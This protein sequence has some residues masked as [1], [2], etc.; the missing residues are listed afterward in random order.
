MSLR[1]FDVIVVGAGHAGIEAAGAAAR[2][3]CKTLLLTHNLETVGEMSCN[4]AFGGI[5][6]GHLL[7][8]IDAMGGICPRAIDRAGIQFRTL[9]SSKGPA[10]RATRAQT[11]RHLYKEVMRK[12]LAGYP[13]LTLFQ[14]PCTQL[15]FDGDTLC[16]VNT[17][18]DIQFYA[19]A[20]VICAGTFLNG[21]IHIGLN[22]YQGGRAG[23]PASVALAENLKKLGLKQGRLKTGTPARLVS[24]TI[25][26]S[27]MQR[28]EP[29]HPLP[30]FSFI[31]DNSVLPEQVCCHI[32]HT[33]ERTHDIIRS[34]LDRSP[35]YSGVIK[36]TGPRYCPSIEDKIVRYPDRT[37]HQIFVEPEG[38]TSNLVYPNGISTS[39]P[40]DIQEKFIRSIE[41][42]ENVVIARPGYAIEY[43]FYDPRE[44][45]VTMQSK[46]IKGL[47]LAGQI[48]GTTGYEEAAAQGLLAGINAG[49]FVQGK[50]SWFPSRNTAYMGVMMDDLCT[51]GT[52]EP[53]RMFTS[54]AEYRLILR[55]DNA[56][57]RLT[58]TARDLGIIDDERYSFFEEKQNQIEKEKARLRE[59]LVKPSS[60][61]G[62]GVSA[63]LNTP[64]SKEQTL[65]EILRRPESRLKPLLDAAKLDLIAT[66]PQAEEQ[67]EIQVRYQGY[68][69]HELEE[70][71]K[72]ELN[73]KTLLPNNFDYRTISSL[74]NEVAQKLNEFQPETLGMAS[75]ISG[76]TPA[77]ISILLVHLKKLSLLNRVPQNERQQ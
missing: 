20:V 4:P 11:D 44:L 16:G 51:L 61:M 59:T 31:D 55:E 46:K 40:Y 5:G 33:N 76:V 42:F 68:L 29:E 63:I 36:S 27:K 70:I 52:R 6:K 23:D 10:V 24:E 37:A 19:K 54:R 14:Q 72:R 77:A 26:Y 30:V 57:L 73:E 48:N 39:L 35:L 9:N 32:T 71:K 15:L 47:F 21:L 18:A 53:Y 56:D 67:V 74:S 25:N 58:P 8:E 43:D 38:L 12:T 69:E 62:N 50:N 41:G 64:L 2:M 7:R 75:R 65:E 28:Q 22:H 1:E 49:L 66:M 3:G 45:S 34:G 17:A 13:N 60:D